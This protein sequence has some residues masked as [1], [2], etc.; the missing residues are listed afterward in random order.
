MRRMYPCT[1][2]VECQ[3]CGAVFKQH[4]ERKY[5]MERLYFCKNTDHNLHYQKHVRNK[6]EMKGLLC[7][8]YYR[9]STQKLREENKAKKEK[10]TVTFVEE[11]EKPKEE[12]EY[13][14]MLRKH[15]MQ[16][17]SR[18]NSFQTLSESVKRRR[19]E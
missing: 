10:I 8:K 11:K 1:S 19:N 14:R 9:V 7:A 13:Y 2:E 5:D 12:S 16:S 17:S 4:M 6:E 18:L 3:W 15:K